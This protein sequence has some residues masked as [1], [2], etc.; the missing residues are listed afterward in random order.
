M[1]IRS[2]N[3]E[4]EK[5]VVRLSGSIQVAYDMIMRPHQLQACVDFASLQLYASK[6]NNASMNLI[7]NMTWSYN[8]SVLKQQDP[9]CQ[10]QLTWPDDSNPISLLPGETYK[11]DLIAERSGA[12]MKQNIA[13]KKSQVSLK[14][15]TASTGSKA[16]SLAS[17]FP[18]QQ[19]DSNCL[20]KTNCLA[21]T[22]DSK[23]SWCSDT[24]T[25]LDKSRDSY[26]PTLVKLASNQCTNC[27]YFIHCSEC[28]SS[29]QDG[30]CEWVLNEARCVR[31]GRFND[32]V[33]DL[34]QCPDSCQNRHEC[35]QCIGE[36]GRCV[37]CAELGQC[38][39]F[40]LYTSEY[41]YGQCKSWIDKENEDQ[42]QCQSCQDKTNCST[43]LQGLG[44]G[45]CYDASNPTLGQ[46]LKGSFLLNQ[47]IC[48][49]EWSYLECPD[50][51]ECQLNLH[52]CHAQA[53][54]FNTHGSYQ[55]HCNKGFIG[56]GFQSCQ[57]T[58][59]EDCIHGKCSDGPD[60]ACLCD[61]GW[62]GDD[63]NTDC[64]CFGHSKCEKQGPGKCDFCQENTDG[65]F[66][67]L[68]AEGSYG[69]ATAQGCHQCQCNQHGNLSA[70]LCD[71]VNGHC[72]CLH[73][74]QG[75]QCE[76]CQD[77]FFGDPRNGGHCYHQCS[78]KSIIEKETT[79]Y[80]GCSGDEESECLWMI[81][82]EHNN[83]LIEL[84]WEIN[85][86]GESLLHKKLSC[87]LNTQL[88]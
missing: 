35:N 80:V 33:Q 62:T 85:E 64:G 68:C 79:G 84:S 77:G 12:G 88:S 73:H 83:S 23:C 54:C 39:Q 45:W 11:I 20:S 69:N 13:N 26:C 81:K 55:C 1:E 66:C 38:F 5:Y 18:F 58:C 70:G 31:K 9:Y 15:K 72:F 17:L 56:D 16:L 51:D 8:K 25:C 74:T 67:Q 65:E 21:C 3:E 46:C 6:G 75:E 82:A 30:P 42:V 47:S 60:Y 41:I 28:V 86:I 2:E 10:S 36:P 24:Q 71:Q 40:S 37:W 57:R 29:L 59:Y 63:C 61:L 52:E 32:S 43:C 19:G 49:Q 34:E 27:S 76:K 48:T 7:K 78:A 22:S 53:S 44:C 87:F 4:D 14:Q 50:I